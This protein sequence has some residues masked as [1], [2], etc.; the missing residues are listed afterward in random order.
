MK[1]KMIV[2]K[3]KLLWL[4]EVAC[5][6]KQTDANAIAIKQTVLHVPAMRGKNTVGYGHK[7]TLLR[8]VVVYQ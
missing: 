4:G 5:M 2:A 6:H 8:G 3:T 1:S 7:Q